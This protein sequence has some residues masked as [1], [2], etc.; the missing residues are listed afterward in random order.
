MKKLKL[1]LIMLSSFFWGCQQ[2]EPAMPEDFGYLTLGITVEVESEPA[3]GRISAVNTDDFKVTIFRADGSEY[4]VIDPYSSA[5]PE[6]QLP[7]GVYYVEAHSNDLV[8]AAFDSPYYFAQSDTFS[9]DKEELKT[10]DVEAKLANAKVAIN[11]STEVT[12]VFDAYSGQ[13]EVVSS[14]TTLA[15]VQGETREG[16]FVVEPLAVEVYLSYTK[17]DGSTIDRTFN[18]SI[19]DPQPATLYNINVDATLEDGAI[20]FNLTV[21]EGVDTVDI[22][23]G[24]QDETAIDGCRMTE[25]SIV[26]GAFIE[27]WLLSYDND[28]RID[29]IELVDNDSDAHWTLEYNG[30]GQLIRAN[31]YGDTERREDF[32]YDDNGN[33]SIRERYRDYGSGLEH[34]NHTEY[35]YNA[36]NQLIHYQSFSVSGA[37][38]YLQDDFVFTYTDNSNNPT[39]QDNYDTDGNLTQYREFIY[40]DKVNTIRESGLWVCDDCIDFE[41][42]PFTDNNM[43]SQ[44]A[45]LPDGTSDGFVIASFVYNGQGYLTQAE[46]FDGEDSFQHVFDME[47]MEP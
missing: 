33:L 12:N 17:L 29:S 20:V 22:D 1:S 45:Y 43:D 6:V 42:L 23:L 14:G 26:E 2:D 46:Y 30:I 44:L 25:F 10:I 38:M 5:P 16:Y 41:F 28:G 40:D 24:G 34:S 31:G 21:D 39:R 9:I 18:T 8:E 19:D 3:S 11:F 36:Q 27:S 47:C 7:T 15:Y 37:N 4:L 32:I 35:T 13:V